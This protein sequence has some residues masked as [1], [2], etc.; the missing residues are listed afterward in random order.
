MIL[1]NFDFPDIYIYIYI[2]IYIYIY[3]YI[4]CVCV[5]VCVC[6]L[7]IPVRSYVTSSYLQ[8]TMRKECTL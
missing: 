7:C 1:S 8:I 6:V 3:I 4:V 2:C 5:C